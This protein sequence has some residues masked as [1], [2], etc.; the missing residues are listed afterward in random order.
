M[1][2]EQTYAQ[3]IL[4]VGANE[5]KYDELKELNMQKL[6]QMRQ[7][8]IENE[9]RRQIE[10][11][12]EDNEQARDAYEAKMQQLMAMDDD[13]EKKETEYAHLSHEEQNL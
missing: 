10:R 9:N 1:T 3:L 6:Q 11:P 13:T 7:L 12:A 4:A 8:K 2:K 5:Q